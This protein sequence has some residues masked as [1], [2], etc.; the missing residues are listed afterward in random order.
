[1]TDLRPRHNRPGRPS[2]YARHGRLR[3]S[4]PFALLA[5]VLAAVLG[6]ALVSGFSVAAI[7]ALD[8]MGSAKKSVALV[9]KNGKTIAPSIGAMDGAFNVLL[10]GS[11]SGDG[12]PAYG[13]RG[14]NL[15]DVT[16]VMHVSKDHKNVTVVSLPRDMFVSI[17]SCPD[18]EGGSFS[19]MSRQ[20]INTSLSYGGLACTV[21]T[22][23]KLTGLTIPYAAMIEFDGVVAMSNAV[24]GVPVCLAGRLD[25]D[26]VNPPLHLDA[27]NYTL[28]GGEALSYLR[29]RHSIGDGSDLGRISNQQSFLSSLVRTIKS[30]KTLSDPGKIYGL[31]KAAMSNMTLSDSLKS[32][33]TMASMAV[34]LKDIDL[35]RVV[36]VQ[37][38]NHYV[39]GGVEPSESDA[40]ALF[41]ALNSDKP[42]TLT[43]ATGVGAEVV[44][45]NGGAQTGGPT[46]SPEPTASASQ[47]GSVA[48][49]ETVQGQ[50]A[51]Q[52]T[53]ARPYED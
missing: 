20:K 41:E 8:V 44:G 1:M 24:G 29:T 32:I 33:P 35:T 48:L 43:G 47:G 50:T 40:D 26:L 12:N 28:K 16:M 39:D 27:G 3:R 6:V 37:Y 52:Q 51:A 42:I 30:A 17:P 25:D 45:G 31:A 22:V 13:D 11:D 9:D 19:A 23:E 38:P 46:P 15:N 21:L 36:F 4:N 2:T 14:E 18:P 10:A 5:K 7:A 34:A 49:P 53:C